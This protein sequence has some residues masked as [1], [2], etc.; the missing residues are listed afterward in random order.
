VADCL[1]RALLEAFVSFIVLALELKPEELS[2]SAQLQQLNLPSSV[3]MFSVLQLM[4][5]QILQVGHSQ[6]N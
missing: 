5:L 6:I 4:H 1:W 2:R 3:E